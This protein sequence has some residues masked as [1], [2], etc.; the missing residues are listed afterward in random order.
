LFST[1]K[2]LQIYIYRRSLVQDVIRHIITLY[3]KD[4]LFQAE[5]PLQNPEYPEAYELRFIEDDD[6]Y[7]LPDYDMGPLERRDEIGEFVSLAFV[8]NKNFRAWNRQPEEE[9]DEEQ[10]DLK[11]RHVIYQ[12]SLIRIAKNDKGSCQ[13]DLT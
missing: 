5:L 3:T 8:A 2:C 7:Y 4:P 13:H 6:D 12:F 9:K 11:K 10:E 1:P